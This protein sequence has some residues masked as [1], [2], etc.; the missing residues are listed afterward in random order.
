[1]KRFLHFS[2]IVR[3]RYK[4]LYFLFINLSMPFIIL[5]GY[6]CSGKTSRSFELRDYFENTKRLRTVIVSEH[7]RGLQ[8]NLLYSGVL[9]TRLS[10]NF[11]SLVEFTE[12]TEVTTLT[13]RE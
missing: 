3:V 7:D 5:C 2:L 11:T 1:M 4:L 12:L 13:A 9:Y 8:R 10:K 6:P